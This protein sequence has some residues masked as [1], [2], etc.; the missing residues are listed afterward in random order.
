M[1]RLFLLFS[2]LIFS[3]FFYNHDILFYV[4]FLYL[5]NIITP[6]EVTWGFTA[7]WGNPVAYSGQLNP[8][9]FGLRGGTFVVAGESV[10]EV[11][12]ASDLSYM[13]ENAVA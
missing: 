2:F 6:Q 9:Q 3:N 1:Q 7:R 10:H 11:V 5:D 8:G 4:R 13:Y 12:S